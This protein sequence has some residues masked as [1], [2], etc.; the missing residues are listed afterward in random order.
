ME[1]AVLLAL[2]AAVFL[3]NLGQEIAIES[4]EARH[5][6]IARTMLATGE[7]MV[8]VVMGRP[9]VDKPPLFNWA[10]AGLFALTGR[11]DFTIAR[12]PSALCAIASMLG[13][14]I[15][16]RRWL[17]PRAGVL[18]AAIWATSWLAVE[19]GR[20]ARMDMMMTC[21]VLYGV[22]VA[23]FAATAQSGRRQAFIW[24]AACAVIGIAALS[25]GP[26][27]LF[28]FFTA[29]VALWRARC[30]RW[31]P[32]VWLL[33]AGLGIIALPFAVWIAAA[34]HLHP[35]HLKA[36]F[37]YQLGEGLV[38]HPR[39]ITLF[40][41]QLILRTM[42]WALFAV[43]GCYLAALKFRRGGYAREHIAP[44]VVL[45]CLIVM[46]F[47]PNRR[48]LYL[49]PMLPMWVLFLGGFIDWA[50]ATRSGDSGS[51]E[52]VER[53]PGWAFDW[54]V[55]GTCIGFTVTLAGLLMTWV[56]A[57]REHKAAGTVVFGVAFAIITA[58]LLAA[59]RRKPVRA[60]MGLL[61]SLC[62]TAAAAY[63]FLIPGL[64]LPTGGTVEA[65]A[66][67][68]LIAP[69]APVANYQ[70]KD[71]YLYFKL[72][73]PIAFVYDVADLRDFLA[74]PGQRYVLTSVKGAPQIAGITSRP[75]RTIA[76]YKYEDSDVTVLEIG[77]DRASAAA[78]NERQYLPA[79]S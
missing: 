38:Q 17:T 76:S 33:V 7:Y 69:G 12:L 26:I 20:A 35:G 60:A 40:F 66:A 5:A 32:P 51:G 34:E 44:A 36:L 48:A 78:G 56:A 27:V 47:V 4:R 28:F 11:A 25:K 65:R 29:V 15:L 2:G 43:G 39:R 77:S 67:A 46:T 14:Y 70:A 13:V 41:D 58:S 63:P 50:L 71:E 49:L 55:T 10:A 57:A 73:R 19:W 18:A 21:L 72:A 23:D 52:N 3:P 9:Y 53:L 6:E 45:V 31:V 54:T 79:A 16:G 75:V 42:P 59:L 62:I 68:A 8:P 61:V 30:K 74:G 37:G 24:L 64:M 22:I 1:V